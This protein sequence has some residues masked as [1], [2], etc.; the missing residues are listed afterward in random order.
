MAATSCSRCSRLTRGL[1][2][3]FVGGFLGRAIVLMKRSVSRDEQTAPT[4]LPTKSAIFDFVLPIACTI[5]GAGAGAW[6]RSCS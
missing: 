5:V 4:G 2:G 3:A 6:K 1:A